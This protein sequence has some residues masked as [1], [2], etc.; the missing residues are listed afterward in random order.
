MVLAFSSSLQESETYVRR[1]AS[2]SGVPKGVLKHHV[3]YPS[4]S[5][6][7]STKGI[8]AHVDHGK[9]TIADAL[10]ASN[11]IISQRMSGQV[12]FAPRVR[13]NNGTSTRLSKYYHAV[14]IC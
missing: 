14:N 13:L 3:V 5:L 6:S 12:S 4:F 10:L 1:F 9:T 8:L 7:L 11:G 2:C